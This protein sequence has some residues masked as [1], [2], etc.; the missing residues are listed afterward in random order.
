MSGEGH[1][2]LPS[3]SDDDCP[4]YV[5]PVSEKRAA[6]DYALVECYWAGEAAER[7]VI[8]GTQEEFNKAARKATN[9]HRKAMR[10]ADEYAKEK[11]LAAH[12]DACAWC[13]NLWRW[14]T[15]TGYKPCSERA[16][17]EK[18]EA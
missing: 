4:Q 1:P 17:L 2:S 7:A 8:E 11:A 9:A 5:G 6:L 15:A 13:Q 10:L 18:G 3:I 16:G 12:E 14:P